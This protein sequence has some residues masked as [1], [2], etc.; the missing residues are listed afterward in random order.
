MIVDGNVAKWC[1]SQSDMISSLESNILSLVMTNV[2]LLERH[3]HFAS[4]QS[5][6]EAEKAVVVSKM[7]LLIENIGPRNFEKLVILLKKRQYDQCKNVL[8]RHNIFLN[9]IYDFIHML[10]EHLKQKKI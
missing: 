4:V 9:E 10:K 1:E 6:K 3:Q 5:V 8:E 2:P 7:K